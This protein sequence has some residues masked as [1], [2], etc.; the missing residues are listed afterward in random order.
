LNLKRP[1]EELQ[2]TTL[3]RQIIPKKT[4]RDALL[5]NQ[6]QSYL[7]T[8]LISLTII[9]RLPILGSGSDF[10]PF[11][12]KV[13]VT[14][15]DIRYH[16]DESLGLSSYPLYHSVYET[17]HLVDAFLDPGFKVIASE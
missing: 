12:G 2:S 17:F 10:A 4:Q 1:K 15:A 6:S 8:D 3:G 11:V 14:C 13:G 16:Y 5:D 7:L 9:C